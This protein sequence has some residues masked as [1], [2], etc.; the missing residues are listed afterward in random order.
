VILLF[1]MVL[2][3]LQ[4]SLQAQDRDPLAMRIMFDWTA[5]GGVSGAVV[6][7]A[8]WLTDPGNPN[9]RLADQMVRG[10]ALG[11]ILGAGYGLF[12][13]Q[14]SARL[15]VRSQVYIRDPLD[16]RERITSDPVAAA[17]GFDRP[18]LSSGLFRSGANSGFALPVLSFRF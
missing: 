17:S 8:V 5:A 13:L 12:I 9:I 1:S 11:V 6:G 10:T 15:P 16:P 4:S 7:F 3:L 2:I 14:R 18:A